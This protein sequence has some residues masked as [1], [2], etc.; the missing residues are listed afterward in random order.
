MD[1]FFGISREFKVFGY[2][3]DDLMS[4]DPAVLRAILIERT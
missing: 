2:S 4:M 3:I 1:D